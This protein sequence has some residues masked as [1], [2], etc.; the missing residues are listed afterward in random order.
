MKYCAKCGTQLVDEA[1]V[2]VKCGC[3]T[4]AY[5]VQKQTALP[6]NMGLKTAIKI[7]MVITPICNLMCSFIFSFFVMMGV[8][9]TVLGTLISLSWCIPMTV[10]YFKKVKYNL[11]VS[12]GFKVC[13]LL[14]VNVI[15]GFLMLCDKDN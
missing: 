13:S 1:V 7:L 4:E 2:C 5:Y 3:P 12:T 6:R 9:S 11:P 15:A 10:S 8:A 14:F